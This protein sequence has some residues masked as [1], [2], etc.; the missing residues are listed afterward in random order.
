[1]NNKLYKLMNWPEI[2][3]I[4]YS[5]GDDPHRILGAHKMG[6]SYLI[7]T[8]LPGAQKVLIRIEGRANDVEMEMADDAGFFAALVPYREKMKYRYIATDENGVE[9]ESADPYAFPPLITRED[10]IRFGNGTLYHAFEKLGA[11]PMTR[12]GVKGVEFAVWAPD[13][14]RVSVIG[15]WNNWDGRFHQMQQ[16]DRSGIFEIFVPYAKPGNAYQYEIKTKRGILYK[17]TDP[18]AFRLKDVHGD[19]SIITEDPEFAW[20]D[21][22]FLAGRRK[23]KKNEAAVSIG[24]IY[25]EDFAAWHSQNSKG[26]ERANCHDI[27]ADVISYVKKCGYSTIV[28][29]PVM[30]HHVANPYEVTG[31]FAL[32]E[33]VGTAADLKY[34][35]NELHAAGVRVLIDWAPVTFP[36]K[37]MGLACYNGEALYEYGG[38]KGIQPHTGYHIFDY[39]RKQVISYLLSNAIYW[40]DTFHVDGFRFPDIA[41]VIYLDYDR[42][43]GGWTPNV[44]GGNENLEALE[45]FRQFSEIMHKRDA[46]ILTIVRETA[47][48]P[49]VTAELEEGGLGFAFKVNNGWSEDFLRYLEHDPIRRSGAHNELT[50]SLLYCYTERFLLALGSDLLPGGVR[51]LMDRLPGDEEAR[52]AGVRQ[53]IAYMYTHPGGKLLYAGAEEI[54]GR[55]SRL[56]VMIETLEKIYEKEPALHVLDRS[57][58]GFE[59]IN[60]MSRDECMLSFLR[61]GKK[62]SENLVV[63]ANFAG[64]EQ[65]FIVG[66]PN[67]GKY[68]EI[69]NSDDKKFGGSGTVN[70]GTIEAHRRAED[71]RLYSINLK[72]APLSLAIYNYTPYTE[73]EKK[74]RAIKEQDEIKKEEERA[75]KLAQLK[76][77]KEKEQEKLLE[78]LK[79]R[80]E[81]ELAAQE[82]A[83]EEKYAKIEEERVKKIL[84][85]KKK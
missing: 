68:R 66:V 64:V 58:D 5:D 10:T 40:V 81:K 74:I 56:P 6:N 75:E 17:K 54:L 39:G 42:G 49:Q 60:C 45:F 70:R 65:E 44:Y 85:S 73:Q 43:P 47:C 25:L 76:R 52:E 4:I 21:D 31:Y 28:L 57:E 38:D 71:G 3:E 62:A 36:A 80:Y 16:V 53:A 14:A 41:K 7:Q 18:F 24:E 8:F 12:D 67:D 11:H 83:I 59:W 51:S 82:K 55:D 9:Y 30:E 46:G 2:E 27:A 72:L 29:L 63:V 48:Y 32:S 20:T 79:L 78:D 34:F 1:M 23:F 35:V 37:D 50:F 77:R 84:N 19:V 13:V 69:F 15:E 26:K 33:T 22:A 61:K